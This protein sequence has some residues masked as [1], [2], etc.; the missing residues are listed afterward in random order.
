MD[1]PNVVR[2]WLRDYDDVLPNRVLSDVMYEVAATTR[3]EPRSWPRNMSLIFGTLRLAATGALVLA[4]AFV[5]HGLYRSG[6]A[7]AAPAGSNNAAA[8]QPTDPT[9]EPITQATSPLVQPD[10]DGGLVA[11]PVCADS[12]KCRIWIVNPDGTDSHQL[13]PDEP[14]HQYPLAWSPDGSR[15]LYEAADFDRGM[16][17]TRL[18]VTD[19]SGRAPDEYS[20]LC[21]NES[22]ATYHCGADFSHASFSPDGTRIVYVIWEYSGVGDAEIS[23]SSLAILNLSSGVVTQ[24]ESTATNDPSEPCTTSDSEGAADSP[25]WSPDGTLIAFARGGIGPNADGVCMDALFI[26]NVA[27]GEVSEIMAPGQLH[28]LSPRWS[29]DGSKLLFDATTFGPVPIDLNEA[30]TDVYIL[31]IDGSGFHSI[32]SDG[33]SVFPQWTSDGR[34]TFVRWTDAMT[35]RGDVWVMDADGSNASQI[36]PS[37]ASLTSAGCVVCPHPVAGNRY[38][39]DQNLG[40]AMWRPTAE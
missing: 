32:T 11:Y 20:A 3:R 16:S 21:A 35:G 1:T 40:V 26:L 4:L 17:N 8:V 24:L 25:S 18:A 19:A 33:I 7:P 31:E 22:H 23:T 12:G 34:I 38:W 30:S 36:D 10:S 37:I 5:A 15:L 29:P 9:P 28:G 14:G 2:S 13:L 6:S 39:K 27:S